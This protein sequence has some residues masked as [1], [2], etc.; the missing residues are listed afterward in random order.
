MASFPLKEWFEENDLDWNDAYSKRAKAMVTLCRKQRYESMKQIIASFHLEPDFL[1]AMLESEVID[2]VDTHHVVSPNV[3]DDNK[4]NPMEAQHEED[5]LSI[6]HKDVNTFKCDLSDYTKC[7]AM[8]RLVS[9]LEHYSMLKTNKTSDSDDILVQFMNDLY[10]GKD[11]GLINDYIHFKEHHEHELER[12][13][14]DLINSKRFNVCSIRKCEFTT[15]HMRGQSTDTS[16]T[17]LSFHTETF[18]AL[19]FH[20]FHCFEAGLRLERSDDNGEVDEEEE[21]KANDEYFD[22]EFA[23]MNARILERYDNTASFDRFLP[24][25]TKF[26]ILNEEKHD[27]PQSNTYR[28]EIVKHLLNVKLDDVP[29]KQFMHFINQ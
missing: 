25:N 7:D 5:G 3:N 21:K 18:D 6:F 4:T 26:N 12:I 14:H 13:H 19:H 20:F 16:D 9:S 10:N 8:E 27:T 15:R 11:Q 2:W 1:S 24:K 17:K 23:R 28:D 29:I 22:A